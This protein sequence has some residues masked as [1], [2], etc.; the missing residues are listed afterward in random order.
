MYVDS[1]AS[2]VLP[3]PT[4]GVRDPQE[5]DPWNYI[6]ATPPKECVVGWLHLPSVA[7]LCDL[8]GIPLQDE[9]EPPPDEL[10]DAGLRPLLL[11]IDDLPGVCYNGR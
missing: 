10:Q 9:E 8:A 5:I 7:P 6:E 4:V 1:E 11:K 3:R 2:W